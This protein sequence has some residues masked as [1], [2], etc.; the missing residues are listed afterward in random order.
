MKVL[1][2]L[3][4]ISLSSFT[5]AQ[6]GQAHIHGKVTSGLTSLGLS[7]VEVR[8]K[9]LTPEIDSVITYTNSY[10][11]YDFFITDVADEQE[12]QSLG[13]IKYYRNTIETP[14][15]GTVTVSNI[16]GEELFT[17]QLNKG[18]NELN[19]DRFADGIY[20]TNTRIRGVN[21]INKILKL[22]GLFY[23]VGEISQSISKQLKQLKKITEYTYTLGFKDQTE[24]H[25]P[26]IILDYEPLLLQADYKY[27]T[28]LLPT[29][30]IEIPFTNPRNGELVIT[31]RDLIFYMQGVDYLLYTAYLSTVKPIL[32]HL[33]IQE[34]PPQYIEQ[35]IRDATLEILTETGL[36][37]DSI[38][39]E[40]Q[41]YINPSF[42]N[43]STMGYKFLDDGAMYGY[44][45]IIVDII[46]VSTGKKSYQLEFNKD[47]IEPEYI[48]KFIKHAWFG[49][50]VGG[51]M[52]I[53]GYFSSEPTDTTIQNLTETE[54][55]QFRTLFSA[56]AKP[57][58]G[59]PW[60]V[61]AENIP[62][63]ND[64]KPQRK[65]TKQELER[66]LREQMKSYAL[67]FKRV[68]DT[69]EMT[70]KFLDE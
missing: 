2:T 4:L 45:L 43:E 66:F 60:W 55:I 70:K 53:A 57:E 14:Y 13:T 11:E 28:P 48:K 63:N 9:Q 24:T 6:T 54:R 59:M 5:I 44:D 18:T 8:Y 20:F 26:Y 33:N 31:N 39:Q 19:L 65:A 61:S 35:E 23:G 40:T 7:N 42:V 51:R 67:Y 22:N 27:S 12:T 16:L 58:T 64:D 10:G 29:G 21:L 52:P 17:Q 50:L 56:P 32:T 30:N 62:E 68:G 37:L 69:Y 34:L 15:E 46:S 1:F 25:H 49:A 3:I 36:P 38:Y 47:R 41:D